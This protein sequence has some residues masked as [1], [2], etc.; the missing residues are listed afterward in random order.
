MHGGGVCHKNG[1]KIGFRFIIN[2]YSIYMPFVYTLGHVKIS[3]INEVISGKYFR[4]PDLDQ[5][6]CCFAKFKV[7]SEN[8]VKRGPTFSEAGVG[9]SKSTF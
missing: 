8:L 9:A 4:S 5:R 2:D 7:S 1:L 3:G 6:I